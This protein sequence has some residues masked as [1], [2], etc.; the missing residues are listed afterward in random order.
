MGQERSGLEER[1]NTAGDG[2]KKNPESRIR[3]SK[4]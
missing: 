2:A 3:M 1:E 4:V